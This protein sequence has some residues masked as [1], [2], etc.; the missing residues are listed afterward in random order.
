[1]A[2]KVQLED[3][4]ECQDLIQTAEA[5]ERA[6][7]R[8]PHGE[9]KQEGCSFAFQLKNRKEVL[10]LAGGAKINGAEVGAGGREATPNKNTNKESPSPATQK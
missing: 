4:E 6:T 7:R 9:R 1:M 5:F 2:W 10:E 3:R 8:E